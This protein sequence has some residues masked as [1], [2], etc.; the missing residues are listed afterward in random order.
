[1]I[2]VLMLMLNLSKDK[3][4]DSYTPIFKDYGNYYLIVK[5][6][7]PIGE[8]L[9]QKK[10]NFISKLKINKYFYFA[11]EKKLINIKILEYALI[12][13]YYLKILFNDLFRIYFK[14]L[15]ILKIAQIARNKVNYKN[16]IF[17]FK[18]FYNKRYNNYYWEVRVIVKKNKQN[19]SYCGITFMIIDSQ[20]GKIKSSY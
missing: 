19:I 4:Y 9:Y 17:L 15:S 14:R 1:M 12:Y 16:S 13:E 11:F 18:E 20:T 10:R 2:I 6:K 5:S 8:Y 3:I 7:Y